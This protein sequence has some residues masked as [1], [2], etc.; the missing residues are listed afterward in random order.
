MSRTHEQNL[1][2]IQLNLSRAIGQADHNPTDWNTG[3]VSRLRQAAT[4]YQRLMAGEIER[5]QMCHTA[6]D[7]T[8]KMPAW[9]TYG[10]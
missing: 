2:C 7:L 8:T 5:H 9:A 6:Q 10:T 4:D 3:R 1:D